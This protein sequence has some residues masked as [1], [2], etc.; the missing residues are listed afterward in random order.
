[1]LRMSFHPMWSEMWHT[2]CCKGH[3]AS[4]LNETSLTETVSVSQ[5]DRQRRY[6]S[7][8]TSDRTRA[9]GLLKDLLQIFSQSQPLHSNP[10]PSS[11]RYNVPL[12]IWYNCY[13][14]IV[15]HKHIFLEIFQK[16]KDD[17]WQNVCFYCLQ[18]RQS[19]ADLLWFPTKVCKTTCI[20]FL[21]VL[22]SLLL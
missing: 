18:Q 2:R 11:T 7:S 8:Q 12:Q 19:I 9:G 1:M 4:F 5:F 16:K 21:P 3:R 17:K 15:E 13:N 22:R 14:N 10:V 6:S 20:I